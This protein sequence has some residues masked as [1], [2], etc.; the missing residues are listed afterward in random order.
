MKRFAVVCSLALLLSVGARA[1]SDAYRSRNTFSAFVD[2]SW[3]SSHIL[4]G[5]ARNRQMLSF[6]AG[7]ARRVLTRKTG[8]VSYVAEWRPVVL[9]S[10]PMVH[11][12]TVSNSMLFASPE[13]PTGGYTY[14]SRY[15]AVNKCIA[16]NQ[17]GVFYIGGTFPDYYAVNTACGRERTFAQEFSPLGFKYTLRPTHPVQPFIV[18]TLGYMTSSR[19][20]PIDYAGTFNFAFDIGAGVNV[21]RQAHRSTSVEYRYHH[22]SNKNSADQNP[23]VDN[24][25]LKVSYNFG[26]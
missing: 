8:D 10:D 15:R 24:M 2:G 18:G 5:A 19:A 1:Q 7:Y 22:Y 4:L 9:L 23:G 17:M 25:V 26:R 6:G 14:E 16:G 11:S 21:F 13:N 3:T 12:L 20:V